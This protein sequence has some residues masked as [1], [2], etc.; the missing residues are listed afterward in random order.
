MSR[1]LTS[2]RAHSGS[3]FQHSADLRNELEEAI[4]AYTH[5][6]ADNLRQFFLQNDKAKTGQLSDIL[7][8]RA[9]RSIGIHGPVELL[10]RAI[11]EATDLKSGLIDYEAFLGLFA[12]KGDIPPEAERGTSTIVHSRYVGNYAE[13]DSQKSKRP[14]S[15]SATNQRQHHDEPL[16]LADVEG[17]PLPQEEVIAGAPSSRST[18]NLQEE[19]R[20]AADD[21]KRMQS[22]TN[23]EFQVGLKLIAT[24]V[25]QKGSCVKVFRT[26]FDRNHKGNIGVQDFLLGVRYLGIPS[27]LISND[28]LVEIFQS[29][30]TEDGSISVIEFEA[31]VNAG[32]DTKDVTRTMHDR[33]ARSTR[34]P[35]H[36]VA[37]LLEEAQTVS[38]SGISGERKPLRRTQGT[39]GRNLTVSNLATNQ[40]SDPACSSAS[41]APSV[42]ASTTNR[43]SKYSDEEIVGTLKRK[44]ALICSNKY[45]S[46]GDCMADAQDYNRKIT[47]DSLRR[48]VSSQVPN[49]DK[50]YVN[51]LVSYL[52]TQEN[53]RQSANSL[54]ISI[55]EIQRSQVG[56]SSMPEPA[57]I[58]AVVFNDLY[59]L[60]TAADGG[61]RRIDDAI[62][63]CITTEAN[64]S[65]MALSKAELMAISVN[66]QR[67]QGLYTDDPPTP[68]ELQTH[69]S[70][71]GN[72]NMAEGRQGGSQGAAM[73]QEIAQHQR[74]TKS[75]NY[76]DT[77]AAQND[78]ITS[79]V[80]CSNVNIANPDT[81]STR[82]LRQ[83][84]R[85]A[86]LLTSQLQNP[87]SSTQ[88]ERASEIIRTK[89]QLLEAMNNKRSAL[90]E[91]LIMAADRATDPISFRNYLKDFTQESL[92][93]NQIQCILEGSLDSNGKI[94]KEIILKTMGLDNEF[95]A[96][97]D[98]GLESSKLKNDRVS[99][100]MVCISAV[101]EQ[102]NASI[103]GAPRD[104]ISSKRAMQARQKQESSIM[105]QLSSADLDFIKP[106]TPNMSTVA[107]H[108]DSSALAKVVFDVEKNITE[109]YEGCLAEATEAIVGGH[110]RRHLGGD[111][112]KKDNLVMSNGGVYSLRDRQLEEAEANTRR[113]KNTQRSVMEHSTPADAIPR[114]GRGCNQAVSQLSSTIGN[115][116]KQIDEEYLVDYQS[117]QIDETAPAEGGSVPKPVAF[118]V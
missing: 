112:N 18:F 28:D 52:C 77:T 29:Y 45:S 25:L 58:S 68:C 7:F 85:Q 90:A 57:Y 113:I 51:L 30:C 32:E 91:A 12:F 99:D 74:H 89:R 50:R 33:Q 21:L 117:G 75:G 38:A 69:A 63:T 93:N 84:G 100:S 19:M 76:F 104:M 87:A 23:T 106:R 67:S 80:N 59:K 111:L 56:A 49:L 94:Q 2:L 70:V 82:R 36:D 109:D 44:I 27:D 92:T 31:M 9:L 79:Y 43:P 46:F 61:K 17:D 39:P 118:E 116:L 72:L 40:G 47:P 78:D 95:I 13:L 41:A 101:R 64:L 83:S 55:A 53:L 54:G 115:T 65:N 24:Q 15:R 4:L 97:A 8:R 108:Q 86:E 103:S 35:T 105:R 1:P 6:Y 73:A 102:M 81:P 88:A 96:Y 16:N 14:S 71:F 26:K 110:R 3:T 10:N 114:R 22:E 62:W 98:S 34:D 48:F 20:K 5:G 66:N 107:K 11:E 60:P 42:A 37:L